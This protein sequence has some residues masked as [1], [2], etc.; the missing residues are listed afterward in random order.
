MSTRLTFDL[1]LTSASSGYQSRVLRS[2]A[3]EAA[4]QFWLPFTSAQL[5]QLVTGVP[6]TLPA[7]LHPEEFG[8]LLYRALFVEPLET[9]LTDSRQQTHRLR[10]NLRLADAPEL[11]NL[12]WEYLF[13]PA[14]KRFL[15]LSEETPIVRY[16]DLLLGEPALA[17]Q[18]PLRVL[19]LLSSP[20]DHPPVFD[21]QPQWAALEAGLAPAQEKGLLV[22]ERLVEP[23][24]ARLQ[25]RLAAGPIH[26][27]HFTGHGGFDKNSGQGH[28]IFTDP[29]GLAQQVDAEQVADLLAGHNALRLLFFNACEGAVAANDNP[30]TGLAQIVAARGLPAVIAMQDVITYQSA[31]LFAE[32]FYA[33]LAAGLPVDVALTRG[34]LQVYT[35]NESEWATPVLFLRADDAQLFAPLPLRRQIFRRLLDDRRATFAGRDGLL[36]EL[37]AFA[38]DPAG[39]YLLLTAP[40]GFGKTALL[41][42]WVDPESVRVAYH[43]FNPILAPGTLDELNFLQNILEQMA[44]WFGYSDPLPN[45]VAEGQAL[46]QKWMALAG[47]ENRVLVLD[48][49]DEL[50]GAGWS[51]TPYL[52]RLPEGIRVILSAR[53]TGED[54]VKRFL[55]PGDQV[56]LRELDAL[57]PAE[58]QAILRRA[59]GQ[60]A[61]LAD[62]PGFLKKLMGL[63]AVDGDPE[64]GAD[65]FVVSFIAQDAADG[66]FD[67]DLPAG[68][69]IYLDSWWE[70][71]QKKMGPEEAPDQ[72]VEDLFGCLTAALGPLGKADLQSM[73]PSLRDRGIRK[74]YLERTLA[75]VR[76]HIV[77]DDSQ[78]YGLAH[79][80]LRAY[81]AD[82]LHLESYTANLLAYCADWQNNQSPYALAHYARHLCQAAAEGPEN[83]RPAQRRALADLLNNADFRQTH[84]RL[85]Q[86]PGLLRRDI[87]LALAALALSPAEEEL[88]RLVALAFTRL[89]FERQELGPQRL[90][91][92]LSSGDWREIV[93]PLT[94]FDIDSDWQQVITLFLAWQVAAYD[95]TSARSLRRRVQIDA[96]GGGPLPKLA[97]W[98]DNALDSTLPLPEVLPDSYLDELQARM[99]VN[100]LGGH[101]GE[102]VMSSGGEL[103]GRG[104]YFAEEDG[105][106]LVNF[107]RENP[108]TGKEI[109]DQYLAIHTGYYYTEYRNRSLWFLLDAVLGHT[110]D[111][112]WVQAQARTIVEATLSAASPEFVE[113]TAIA[114]RGWRDFLAL[115]GTGEDFA[116][117]SQNA[118]DSS[119]ELSSMR[120][121]GDSFGQH[122]RRLAAYAQTHARL[123]G[124]DTQAEELLKRAVDPQLP[125]GFAGFQTAACLT[126]AEAVRI[127]QPGNWAD[128]RSALEASLRA[129]HNIQ[130]ATFCA[131][132]TARVNALRQGWWKKEVLDVEALIPRL[133]AQ[134][135]EADFAATHIVGEGY[136]QRDPTERLELPDEMRQ[137]RSLAALAPLYK[138]PLSR[139]LELN[140]DLKPDRKLRLGSR[141]RIPDGGMALLLVGRLSAEVLARTELGPDRQ[142]ALLRRLLPIASQKPTVLDTLLSRLL[143]L[144]PLG[145]PA[146]LDA[147]EEAVR[148][149]VAWEPV[150]AA[151]QMLTSFTP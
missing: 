63:A 21:M 7:G 105:P 46:Y 128:I 61:L 116:V 54:W 45:T 28:L 130:D 99:L 30:F 6:G 120:G 104:R 66:A 115:P 145:Q 147:I 87:D 27:L 144:A 103:L 110:R 47:E 11:A 24:F 109:F 108:A 135:E 69:D 36:A 83:E 70:A 50:E 142:L 140:P 127:C 150:D 95:A 68:M 117:G 58:T 9:A 148:F 26:I 67:P 43:F 17:V 121:L 1:Q 79:P 73:N 5:S 123:L 112:A 12:P 34:R 29:Q 56:R 124:Q 52:G 72:A 57:T 139:L 141:V 64:K 98:V 40:A 2:P 49:L 44:G 55:M 114:L 4:A 14:Q 111:P 129:A 8:R 134:A 23:T 90:Y 59:G 122:K 146:L 71:I 39:R 48:G 65:P 137:A 88:P 125:Y 149:C 75:K 92:N 119:R 85:V 31:A 42:N 78:G 151:G 93:R 37:T 143:L 13:D 94:L 131:I 81:L 118:L 102:P 19:A 53:S 38:A 76:R 100:R 84:L 32:G 25:T 138:Q 89:T 41:A 3:G 16:L 22:L 74:G 107:V 20:T 51:L 101:V 96:S 18:P 15:A 126:V 113:G 106:K 132:S 82:R 35:A 91:D 60:A 97:A 133:V 62:D 80:Q 10:L 136:D 86:Q 77:G 33:G